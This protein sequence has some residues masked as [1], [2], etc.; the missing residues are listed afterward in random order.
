MNTTLKSLLIRTC[1]INCG[2][3]SCP[4]LKEPSPEGNLVQILTS[5]T[6]E[7]LSRERTGPAV[8]MRN[9]CPDAVQLHST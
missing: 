8:A 6:V 4:F 9:L 5:L 7:L 1:I 2:Q 3:R